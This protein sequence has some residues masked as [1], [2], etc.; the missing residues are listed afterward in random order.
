MNIFF[1][2]KVSS[3]FSN[4]CD[5][6]W[7]STSAPFQDFTVYEAE[8]IAARPCDE[9]QY[10]LGQLPGRKGREYL[11]ETAAGVDAAPAKRATTL[12]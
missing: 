4:S 12:L 6:A 8:G 5:S 3:Q 9:T 2:F 11:L 7:L 10:L 1:T